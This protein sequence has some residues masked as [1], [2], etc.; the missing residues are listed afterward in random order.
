MAGIDAAVG[1]NDIVHAILHRLRRLL[2]KVVE[3]EAHGLLG[4]VGAGVEEHGQFDGLETLV[5]DIAENVELAVVEHRVRQAHHF[6]M[7]LVGQENVHAHR[8]DVFRERHDE[9][10]A[11]GV[12]GGVGHL[13]EL[14]PEVVEQELRLAAEHCRGRVVAHRCHGLCAA[15]AH[16]HERALYVLSRKSE[17]REA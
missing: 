14:L 7:R 9:F 13:R 6:A 12:D 17:G 10:L 16:R 1:K 5:T 4:V 8:A 11:Y 3:R 2:A 15:G